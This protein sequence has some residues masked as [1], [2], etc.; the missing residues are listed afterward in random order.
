MVKIAFARMYKNVINYMVLALMIAVIMLLGIAS[1]SVYNFQYSRYIPFKDTI[2]GKGHIIF[3]SD[4]LDLGNEEYIE[5][6]EKRLNKLQDVTYS[7]INGGFI[8]DNYISIIG[9]SEEISKYHSYLMAGEWF[10]D[11]SREGCISA[12]VTPDISTIPGKIVSANVNG[13]KINFYIA[14]VLGNNSGYYN[15]MHFKKESSVFDWYETIDY[16]DSF[17]STILVSEDDIKT[18]ESS[19][20]AQSIFLKYS[21]D[22]TA[23]E[24]RANEGVLSGISYILE[25]FDKAREYTEDTIGNKISTILPVLMVAG[26]FIIVSVIGIAIQITNQEI[27]DDVI[28]FCAGINVRMDIEITLIQVFAVSVMG[29]VFSLGLAAFVRETIDTFVFELGV[30]QF[31]FC[32][33]II[34][35]FSIIILGV[36]FM[37]INDKRII[38]KLRKVGQ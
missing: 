19:Y 8:G 14:G 7:L 17:E 18:F 25:E 21:D 30:Y 9:Y 10:T 6:L 13:E 31:T 36:K 28:L 37:I 29:F 1:I 11:A 20:P 12:V 34:I 4:I 32:V 38:E 2:S 35:L 22:I 15:P 23:E 5:N 24:F 16:R 26:L 27:I 3:S 33:G